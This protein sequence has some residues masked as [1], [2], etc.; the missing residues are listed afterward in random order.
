MKIKFFTIGGT[1]DKVYFDKKN[2]YQV[3]NSLLLEILKHVKVGFEYECKSILKKDS[4]DITEKER[5]K[6]F[7][8]LAKDECR[9]IVITHGT[10]TMIQTA[11][12]LQAIPDKVIVLTGSMEPARFRS[13]DAEFNIG[14][15][16]ASVQLL[17]PGVYI[18]MNGRIFDPNKVRKNLDLNRF[19]DT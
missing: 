7:D 18:T 2:D 10:D 1:I 17:P 15:A 6:I 19:E 12:R 5:Q 13:S 8:I 4:L 14:C 9:H 16:I 3:G 11:Q